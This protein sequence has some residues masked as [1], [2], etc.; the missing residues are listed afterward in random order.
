[1]LKNNLDALWALLKK[2]RGRILYY[3]GVVLVLTAIAFAAESY[4][5]SEPEQLVI[6]TAEVSTLLERIQE[7]EIIYPEGM[8]LLRAFSAQP[9]WNSVL[10]QWESHEAMDYT[11]ADGIVIC[12]EDGILRAVGESGAC[13]GFAEVACGERTYVYAS[14]IPDAELRPGAEISAGESIG[15]TDNAMPGEQV[16]NAH[17]H[18]AVL[19]NGRPTDFESLY[20]KNGE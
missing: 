8:E 18:L 3:G 16:L 12:L 4:L 1:M 15:R 14:I 13:G 17:L 5:H 11:I 9:E 10:R 2:N 7:P 20:R 19:E 6:P